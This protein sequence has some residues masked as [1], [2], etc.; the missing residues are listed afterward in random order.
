MKANLLNVQ[1][2][3]DGTLRVQVGRD[4]NWNAADVDAKAVYEWLRE[5]LA[6]LSPKEEGEGIPG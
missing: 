4:D 2:L 5:A 6:K 1:L 3:S